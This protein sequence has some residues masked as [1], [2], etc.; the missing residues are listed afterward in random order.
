[1]TLGGV[2]WVLHEAG[3]PLTVTETIERLKLRQHPAKNKDAAARRLIIKAV[4]AGII[5]KERRG[6]YTYLTLSPR[7]APERRERG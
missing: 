2:A 4:G 3:R 5:L 1:M 7:I 6:N